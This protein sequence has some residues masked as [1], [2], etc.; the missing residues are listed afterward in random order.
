MN[1]NTPRIRSPFWLDVARGVLTAV[2]VA[3]V[4]AIPFKIVAEWIIKAV[5]LRPPAPPIGS[6]VAALVPPPQFAVGVQGRWM[7]LEG[8]PVPKDSQYYKL[9]G[10]E[11][12][13]D[14]RGVFLRGLNEFIPGKRRADEYA[15]PDGAGRSP[16]ELQLDAFKSHSHPITIHRRQFVGDFLFHRLHNLLRKY[17]HRGVPAL[18]NTR[19]IQ[20]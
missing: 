18:T 14:F 13:P 9:T 19:A 20:P 12:L 8:Q 1:E 17:V 3:A 10:R 15:D 16:G 5:T 7:P 4:L 6:I 11:N 2:I